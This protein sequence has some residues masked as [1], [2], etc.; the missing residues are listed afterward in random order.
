VAS[1]TAGKPEE[2]Y[3][4]SDFELNYEAQQATCSEGKVSAVWYERPQP[5]GFVGAEIQ[6]KTQCEG[7]PVHAQCAPGK[8][9]RT[10]NVNPYHEI[11]DQRRAEQETEDWKERMKRGPAVEGTISELTL[12]HGA[13]DPAIVG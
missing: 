4:Q 10:L 12:A 1:D 11:L 8:S 6:F 13:V 5:D 9:G 2:G 7:C 3:R